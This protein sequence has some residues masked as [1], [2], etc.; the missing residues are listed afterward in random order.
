MAGRIGQFRDDAARRR[1]A[2][3]YDAALAAWPVPPNELDIETRFGSTH[4]LVTGPTDGT[5]IVLL[6]A[7]AVASPSWYPNIAALAAEHGVYA[8]DTIGDVGRSTQTAAVRSG[9]DI[10][11]WL[12]DVLAG[13]DLARVHLVGLSYGGWV[14]LN[15][16]RRS[17]GRLASVTAVD[18]V[19]SI[20]RAQA[21][22][23]LR[24]APDSILASVF[25]SDPALHRLLRLLNNG[26]VPEEPLLE[27]SI[28]GLRTFRAKQP[29]PKR[30]RDDDLRAIRTPTQLLFCGR[31][32]VNHA[33]KAAQRSRDLIPNATVGVISDSGHMLPVEQPEVFASRVLDFVRGLGCVEG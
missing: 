33:Q 2:I 1:Y 15:Q 13:L 10:A 23:L 25:K 12:D 18:P 24:I 5:P 8:I 31:S 11:M 6:H 9:D 20:G 17:P 29:F 26:T 21:T 22:F 3:A 4:L 16:A 14:A 30:L 28:A 27:L 7:V 32:P 19:G